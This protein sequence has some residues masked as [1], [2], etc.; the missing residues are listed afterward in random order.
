MVLPD[1]CHRLKSLPVGVVGADSPRSQLGFRLPQ[2]EE[3]G[4][5]VGEVQPVA[6]FMTRGRETRERLAVIH[7]HEEPRVVN[8]AFV[9]IG[10][11]PERGGSRRGEFAVAD[12]GAEAVSAR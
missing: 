8:A 5:A 4:M 2:F 10:D 9:L 7:R 6:A 1:G 3:L 12:E 11:Y